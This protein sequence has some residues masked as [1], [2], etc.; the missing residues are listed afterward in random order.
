[1]FCYSKADIGVLLQLAAD[2][3]IVAFGSQQEP[4]YIGNTKFI[5]MY[6]SYVASYIYKYHHVGTTLIYKSSNG[7]LIAIYI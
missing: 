2:L 5:L 7:I 3:V 1:M 4:I 6:M